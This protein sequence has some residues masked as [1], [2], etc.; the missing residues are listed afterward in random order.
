MK[1]TSTPTPP[2]TVPST[3]TAQR[4]AIPT[5]T[6]CSEPQATSPNPRDS[7][8]ICEPA[9][10]ASTRRTVGESAAI[11]PSTQ[12]CVGTS[13]CPGGKNTTS[14][15]PGSMANNLHSIPVRLPAYWLQAILVS[16]RPS[17]RRAT[18]TLPRALDLPIRQSSTRVYG[19][20]YSATAAR[21]AYGPAMASSTWRF[22]V[23]LLELCTLSRPLDLTISARRP[24]FS[25]LP[26]SPLP[27][28]LI[29]ASAFHFRFHHIASRCSTLTPQS[30]G[31]TSFLSPLTRSFTIAIVFRMS[32]ATCSPFRDR[33]RRTLC[34]PLAT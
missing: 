13:S 22:R 29:T 19:T 20:R 30:I 26:S 23:Y 7:P 16:P 5:P 2:S 24:H 17:L 8:S 21:A 12:A 28:A 32:A 4:L 14:F 27:L 1:S 3:S 11:S 6:F 34:L 25:E 33:S 31:T 18:K 10:S 9:I 15:R